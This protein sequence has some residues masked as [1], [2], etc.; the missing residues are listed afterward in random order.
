MFQ[1]KSKLILLAV[2]S[3]CMMQGVT[4]LAN[5]EVRR[6]GESLRCMCGC[7]YTVTACNMPEC[8]GAKESRGLLLE[9]VEKGLSEQEIQA[10]FVKRYGT[11]VLTAPPAE[12]FNVLA[13]VMPPL[14]IGMGLIFLWWMIQRLRRPVPVAEVDPAILNRYKAS[15]E[16][17]MD[18]FDD[19]PRS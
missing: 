1:S 11:V 6:I 2:L 13:W 16:K 3:A 18:E 5:P 12:G 15:I 14:G 17:D 9:L 19:Q 8:H 7:S 10:E 4:P